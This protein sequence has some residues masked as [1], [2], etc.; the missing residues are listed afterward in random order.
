MQKGYCTLV[1]ETTRAEYRKNA[2]SR[3]SL[4]CPL[5]G[6]QGIFDQSFSVQGIT[7]LNWDW[8][9][10]LVFVGCAC[11]CA[12]GIMKESSGVLVV[13]E[14]EKLMAEY[15]R[16]WKI[17]VVW[18]FMSS[19]ALSTGSHR[20]ERQPS[21]RLPACLPVRCPWLRI[22]NLLKNDRLIIK[23]V[24]FLAWC[25]RRSSRAISIGIGILGYGVHSV[26]SSSK[27]G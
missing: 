20:L 3:Y 27:H 16:R 6:R 21:V 2:F 5:A 12:H 17:N 24:A 13:Q 23:S 4:V 7:R 11:V 10:F 22:I 25:R 26:P 14:M 15:R 8:K 1:G 9:L 18:K 19:E